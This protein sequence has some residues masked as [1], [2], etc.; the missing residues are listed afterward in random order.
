MYVIYMKLFPSS[1]DYGPDSIKGKI[2]KY[3]KIVKKRS[4]QNRKRKSGKRLKPQNR[5]NRE[6]RQL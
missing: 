4:K 6:I 1:G 3:Q 2:N 5:G